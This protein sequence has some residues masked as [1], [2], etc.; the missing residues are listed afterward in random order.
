MSASDPAALDPSPA[1]AQRPRE[2]PDLRLLPLVGSVWSAMA[3][4]LGWWPTRALAWAL[5][6]A[7]LLLVVLAVASAGRRGFVGRR[8]FVGWRGFVGRRV[9]RSAH[10][11]RG[12]GAPVLLLLCSGTLLGAGVGALHVARLSPPVVVTA[13][14][15][16]A[17]VRAQAQVTAD[18]VV[19]LPRD[20]DH[21][22]EPQWSVAVRLESV[23][24]RGRTHTVRVPA[25]LRGPPV[26]DLAFGQR[27]EVTG[28]A[29]QPW[30]RHARAVEL[31]VVGEIEQRSP[32]GPLAGGTSRI[33]QAFRSVC[34]GLPRDAAALLLGLAVGDESLVSA[35]LDAAMIRSGLAH[36]TAVS[37]AN[38]SL[39]VAITLAVVAGL[40]LGWRARVVISLVV[41]GGYVMLVRPEPSVLRAS[42]M[43]VVALVALATG[44]RRRGPPAL[45]AAALI[46][47]LLLPSYA[48]S[49]GFALSFAATG[50]LLVVGPPLVE[51]LRRWPGTRW[52]PEPIRL[53][54]AVAASAHLATL[55]LVILMG[56]GA[57]LVALAANVLAMPFVPFA[58]L[59][60]L[61]AA[62]VAVW[63][64]GLATVMAAVASP[65]TGAIAWIAHRSAAVPFAVIEGITGVRGAVLA[66]AGLGLAGLVVVRGWRPWRH[67]WLLGAVAVALGLGLA[68]IR[69]QAAAWPPADWV[70]IACDV[71]QGDAVLVRHP[72]S[73][74]ALLV[75]AGPEGERLTACVRGAG[76]ERLAVLITHFHADH[77][78]GLTAVLGRWPVEAIWTTPVPE[79]ADAAA[80][81]VGAAQAAGVPIRSVRAGQ[82]LTAGGVPLTVLWPARRMQHAPVNNSSVVALADVHG[83]AGPIRVLLTGDI[84]PQ[85]QTVLTAGT[86][87]QAE[88]VKVPHHG[89]RHQLPQFATWSG[90]RIALVSAG[91]DNDYGHPSGATLDQYRSTGALI[92]RTDQQGDVAVVATPA[93]PALAA[94]R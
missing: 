55:P 26:E 31:R 76:I 58:T 93:G 90:A 72:G 67:R 36:L 85:A 20:D 30:A 49:M 75:D 28:R 70:V 69:M 19:R 45:L 24:L 81:V 32:P 48:L 59:L 13:V 17:V 87:P 21:R 47:L 23:T 11:N 54:L 65:A 91:A 43:G 92:G 8:V 53:A 38:T 4:V 12:G 46:L 29:Q 82:R 34:A 27:I 60:G 52:L 15:S 1:G 18:P 33:R 63:A 40:G 84:E 35:Q 64:P 2:P 51:R 9:R 37:G 42:A 57:S 6:C 94:R 7:L 25:L 39:V 5:G 73:V 86:P 22:E 62:L 66:A 71:G 74:Q 41:L 79:P 10:G 78:D 80:D 83:I 16:A 77:V 56:N 88:V 44:G 68:V 61:G 50:G 3:A 89:S 14:D